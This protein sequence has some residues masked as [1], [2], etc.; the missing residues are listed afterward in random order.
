VE[1]QLDRDGVWEKEKFD[2]ADHV[3]ELE[4]DQRSG[5]IGIEK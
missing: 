1:G 4:I 3:T 5:S 2:T